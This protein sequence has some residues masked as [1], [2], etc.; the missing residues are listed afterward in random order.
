MAYLHHYYE[1]DGKNEQIRLQQRAK[2]CQI[3]GN[4][5]YK[6]SILGPLLHRVSKTEGQEILYEVHAGICR[7]HIGARALAAKV[8]RWGFYWPTMIDDVARLVATC[9]TCQKLSHRCRAPAQP[10]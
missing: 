10:S 8:L 1:P 2:D 7:G 6:I 4:E 5:L 3:V 9:E